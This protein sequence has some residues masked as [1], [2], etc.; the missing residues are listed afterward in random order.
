M[1]ANFST[2]N[3]VTWFVGFFS[4]V[5]M[6]LVLLFTSR[7]G[8]VREFDSFVAGSAHL[9]NGYDT[10]YSFDTANASCTSADQQLQTYV[11]AYPNG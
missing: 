11:G 9:G 1:A 3:S 4:L 5:V 6:I 8:F 2:F 10:S 7:A